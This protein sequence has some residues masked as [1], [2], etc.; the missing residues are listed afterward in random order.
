MTDTAITAT[1]IISSGVQDGNSGMKSAGVY[2]SFLFDSVK[3]N[4]SWEPPPMAYNRSSTTATAKDKRDVGIEVA[5]L[6]LSLSGS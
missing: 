3:P 6:Q 2:L 4:F 5:L 1:N